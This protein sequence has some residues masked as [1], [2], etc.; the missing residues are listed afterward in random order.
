MVLALICSKENLVRWL[1]WRL[2]LQR[3]LDSFSGT[4]CRYICGAGRIFHVSKE[5]LTSSHSLLPHIPASPGPHIPSSPHPHLPVSHSVPAPSTAVQIFPLGCNTSVPLLLHGQHF[6]PWM[7]WEG[8]FNHFCPWISNVRKAVPTFISLFFFFFPKINVATELTDRLSGIHLRRV[9]CFLCLFFGEEAGKQIAYSWKKIILKQQM[10][11][12]EL[13]LRFC[14][15]SWKDWL[16][17][18][19][20]PMTGE[21]PHPLNDN[22]IFSS[23]EKILT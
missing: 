2:M 22:I 7:A 5:A 14:F 18:G 1:L 23:K 21:C 8:C 3:E 11:I 13:M 16:G 9:F 19:A 10:T 17:N 15:E 12:C 4:Q 20:S 6:P